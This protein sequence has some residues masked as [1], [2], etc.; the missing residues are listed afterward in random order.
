MLARYGAKLSRAVFAGTL[1][2]G[3]AVGAA[4]GARP[5]D[6]EA[7]VRV[8]PSDH[9]QPRRLS[10]SGAPNE[11]NTTAALTRHDRT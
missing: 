8:S 10:S 11:A 1:G 4:L 2:G 9:Q 3:V 6:A 5:A 7:P